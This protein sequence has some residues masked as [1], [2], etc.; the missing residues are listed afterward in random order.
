MH[1]R[2]VRPCAAIAS[3]VDEQSVP[4]TQSRFELRHDRRCA[5]DERER[6]EFRL[7]ATPLLSESTDVRRRGLPHRRHSLTRL[8]IMTINASRFIDPADDARLNRALV[9]RIIHDLWRRHGSGGA[10]DWIG[11]TTYLNE[12]I[13]QSRRDSRNARATRTW[14]IAGVHPSARSFWRRRNTAG[15]DP[16]IDPIRHLN[17]GEPPCSE[18]YC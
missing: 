15:A 5:S 3:V 2:C 7:S 14:I 18:P 16:T 17:Y 13:A 1:H 9:E 4:P 8:R 10:M 12:M 6:G 11:V